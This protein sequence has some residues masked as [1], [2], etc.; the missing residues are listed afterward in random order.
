MSFDKLVVDRI[1]TAVP[2][3]IEEMQEFRGEQTL[4]VT[5][6]QTQSGLPVAAR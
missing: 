4:F 3:A 1:N 2:D 6:E 5:K